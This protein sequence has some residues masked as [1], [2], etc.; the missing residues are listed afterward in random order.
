MTQHAILSASGSAGWLNCPGKLAMEKPFPNTSSEFADEGTAAHELA[1]MCLTSGKDAEAF[2]GRII[3]VDRGEG[4]H[5]T[6]RQFT[7]D[8]DMAGFVQNYVSY[9]RSLVDLDQGDEMF[10]EVEV[11]YTSA[12][13]PRGA[14]VIETINNRTGEVI[15]SEVR[16]FGT[17]DFIGVRQRLK[18]IK[19]LDLKYGRG[20][21]VKAEDNSQGQCYGL[22]VIDMLELAYDIEDDWTVDIIIHQ[23]RIG[24]PSEWQTT[25]GELRKFAI[26]ARV[27]ADHAMHQYLG[28]AEPKLRPGPKQ[29]KWCRAKAVCPAAAAEVREMVSSEAVSADSFDDLT[30]DG[31]PEVKGYGD[32]RLSEAMSK[33][34]FIEDWIKAVRA[35]AERRLLDDQKVVGFKLVRGRQGNRA[36]SDAEAAEELL[37]KS[38]AGS[39]LIYS[40][41]IISPTQAE[42]LAEQGKI[43]PRVWP[44]IEALVTRSEG[45]LHVAPESDKRE[46]VSAKISADAFDDVTEGEDLV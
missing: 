27:A 1:E 39:D 22:G 4:V 44:K 2:I 18:N 12:L 40:R 42:K 34:D 15:E 20:V 41:S 28:K 33:A 29:C 8:T 30:V 3:S 23:P 32:N 6:S 7:V 16:C 46:A 13:F 36:W 45:K 9:A 10:V 5:K 37:K 24:P 21:E 31:K 19:V 25:V 17:S 11:D 26:K 43:G 38:R 14:P 35:E